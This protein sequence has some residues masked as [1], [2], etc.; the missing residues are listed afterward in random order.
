MYRA[1]GPSVEPG[2]SSTSVFVHSGGFS[3][4]LRSS[5]S[6]FAAAAM[7]SAVGCGANAPLVCRADGAFHAPYALHHNR[8]PPTRTP[9]AETSQNNSSVCN[10][11][12]S[13]IV[14]PSATPTPRGCENEGRQ[15]NSRRDERRLRPHC[16]IIIRAGA[17]QRDGVWT[18]A[19]LQQIA[20]T[21][22]AH[23]AYRGMAVRTATNT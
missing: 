20:A 22:L 13:P 1:H 17:T 4:R 8:P 21:R 11:A 7:A 23:R 10:A 12:A 14:C 15:R 3:Q 9:A 19:A 5:S 16:R 18:L 6:S 2:N